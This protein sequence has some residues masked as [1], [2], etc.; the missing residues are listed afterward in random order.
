MSVEVQKLTDEN[1]IEAILF[2]MGNSVELRQLALAIESDETNAKSA[3]E[4]LK[5]RYEEEDR[6]MQIIELESSY[7]MC[8]KAKYYESL[9]RVAKAPKKQVLTDA[10]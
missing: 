5:K 6:A 2:T 1:I 8:T 4:R 3:V 9:I 7:Q 10:V